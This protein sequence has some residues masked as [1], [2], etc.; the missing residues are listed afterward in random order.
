MRNANDG[1][2]RR[3]PLV[4]A[5]GGRT[6][7]IR[8]PRRRAGTSPAPT[9]PSESARCAVGAPLV[10]GGGGANRR[11]IGVPKTGGDK[12]RPYGAVRI[13]EMRR[14]GDPCGRRWRG[15]PRA[16]G[17][18]EDGRGQAP[19]LR[20]R[21]RWAR[22]AVG[23]TLV[24]ARAGFRSRDWCRGLGVGLGRLGWRLVWRG[25]RC[26]RT[27]GGLGRSR[28]RRRRGVRLGRSRR[29]VLG[30]WRRP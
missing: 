13:G 4:V 25:R 19:P 10:V 6:E 27:L 11:P 3:V 9:E 5:R 30:G 24:V 15:E 20:S 28:P 16:F 18:P 2:F 26:R 1:V 23:A 14:R 29:R 7:S 8:G 22:C 21:L 17:V 12:P